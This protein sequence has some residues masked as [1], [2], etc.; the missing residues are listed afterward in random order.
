MT[1]SW[2]S[3]SAGLN[4]THPWFLQFFSISTGNVFSIPCRFL[5][6]FSLASFIVIIQYR[7]HATKMH[8]SMAYVIG[9][10]SGQ[11]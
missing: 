9:K 11:Q 6:A 1:H 8:L 5:D 10:V 4:C 2:L 3:N 7:I